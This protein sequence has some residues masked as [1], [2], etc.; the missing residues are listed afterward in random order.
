[1]VAMVTMPWSDDV[2]ISK[3]GILSQQAVNSLLL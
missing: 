2:I 1:M 3:T